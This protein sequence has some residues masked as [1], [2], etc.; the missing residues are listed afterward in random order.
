MERRSLT[1][2]SLSTPGPQEGPWRARSAGDVY[3]DNNSGPSGGEIRGT[4]VECSELTFRVIAKLSLVRYIILYKSDQ[5]ESSS[6]LI[7]R[8]LTLEIVT[9]ATACPK[10]NREVMF[11]NVQ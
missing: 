2:S 8:G 6:R 3:V 4:L 1:P 9:Y 10:L 5:A 7:G 11:A